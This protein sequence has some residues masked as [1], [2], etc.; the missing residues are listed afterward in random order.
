MREYERLVDEHLV[1]NLHVLC[2]HRHPLNADPLTYDTLPS[3]DGIPN[4][5]VGL[6]QGLT[7]DAG[8]GEADPPGH[9]A[10]LPNDH[11]RAND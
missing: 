4:E 1:L 3:D 9:N 7:H 2:H 8:V 6:D 5:G 11:I 10:V